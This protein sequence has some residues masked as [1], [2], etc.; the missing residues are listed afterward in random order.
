M[1]TKKELVLEA[2]KTRNALLSSN[3]W[4]IMSMISA[5]SSTLYSTLKELLDIEHTKIMTM[6]T[7]SMS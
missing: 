5:E 2:M 1:K 7:E 4:W 6:F 3:E